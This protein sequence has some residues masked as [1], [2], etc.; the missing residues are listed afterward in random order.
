MKS[1]ELHFEHGALRIAV[2]RRDNKATI[3]W[4]GVSDSRNPSA[5]LNAVVQRLVEELQGYE[6]TID[7][8]RLEF[9]NS[10]TVPPIIS[11]IKRLDAQGISSLVLFTDD[12]PPG[13]TVALQNSWL[14]GHMRIHR[15]KF[16]SDERLIA[17]RRSAS[18]TSRSRRDRRRP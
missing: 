16:Q 10:S 8:R 9:M 15:K 13:R 12:P 1:N 7:F 5:F 18:A 3:L 6:V 17:I 11:L 2:F 4:S 14:P